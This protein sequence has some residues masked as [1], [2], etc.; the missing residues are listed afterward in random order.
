MSTN[1][2]YLQRLYLTI[3]AKIYN[4]KL[5]NLQI[6]VN[7]IR[8]PRFKLK[9]VDFLKKMLQKGG[10][11]YFFLVI[12]ISKR[13]HRLNNHRCNRPQSVLSNYFFVLKSIS[14]TMP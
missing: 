3:K 9:N 10:K 7:R 2:C 14:S 4:R 5:T 11:S 1:D 13:L 8:D 12:L 6:P